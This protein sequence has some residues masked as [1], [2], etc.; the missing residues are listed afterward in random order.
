MVKVCKKR[1]A[2]LNCNKDVCLCLMNI[3]S[4][5]LWLRLYITVA[6]KLKCA[7][8]MYCKFVYV[9]NYMDVYELVVDHQTSCN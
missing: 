4:I 5:I 2:I 3:T 6:L 1:F 9:M 8:G 7:M